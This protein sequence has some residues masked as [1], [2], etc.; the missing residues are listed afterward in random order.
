MSQVAK[1]LTM[2]RPEIWF[3]LLNALYKML[4]YIYCIRILIQVYIYGLQ[5]LKWTYFICLYPDILIYMYVFI[6]V[7]VHAYFQL[8]MSSNC[9]P[10]GTQFPLG[11][12]F[13]SFN[14]YAQYIQSYRLFNVVLNFISNLKLKDLIFCW[15]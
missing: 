7:C 2:S 10:R 6:D 4:C 12:Q 14:L 1:V 11:P 15:S 13:S 8:K 9:L 5:L 3:R